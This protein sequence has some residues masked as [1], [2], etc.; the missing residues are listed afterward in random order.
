MSDA[1]IISLIGDH[2]DLRDIRVKELYGYLNKNYLIDAGIKRYILKTYPYSEQTAFECRAESDLLESLAV[3]FT[4]DIPTPVISV[5]GESFLDTEMAGSRVLVRL[6]TF[7]DGEFFSSV[8]PTDSLF[9]SF[10]KFLGELNQSLMKLRIPLLSSREILWDLRKLHAIE[11]FVHLIASARERKLVQHFILNYKEHVLPRQNELKVCLI[12]N[13]A[14]DLNV[15]VKAGQVSGIIDFGDA[16]ESWRINELAIAITYAIMNQDDILGK[17][18]LMVKAFNQVSPLDKVE[19]EVLYYLIG[20]RLCQSVCNSANAKRTDPD[21]EYISVSE[22]AAWSLMARWI[23]INPTDACERFS[24]AAG[25][26]SSHADHLEEEVQIRHKFIPEIVSL[27]YQ[28]PIKMNG[29]AFQYMYGADGTTYLDAYNNIPHVGH[30]HPIVVEAGQR[31]MAR[32][33][34]NTR[35]LY[36]QLADYAGRLLDKFPGPLNKVFFVNS[37][38]E[39]SDLAIRLARNYTGHRGVVVMEH[40]YHG[41]TNTDIEISH[42]KFNNVR[43]PGRSEHIAVAPLPDSYRGIY[44]GDAEA[45]AKY[46]RDLAGQLDAFEEPIAAFISEPVVGCGGQVPLC[47]N[48]LKHVYPEIRRRNALCISDEVQV[49]FGRLGDVFW[50]FEAQGVVPDIVVIGKPM[51]NG[52]PMGAVVTTDKVAAAF[53]QGVEFFSSFGGNP[54]SCEIGQAVLNVLEEE[55]LQNNAREVGDYYKAQ[56]WQLADE[57]PV[58]GDVRGSGL[59]LG[60]ELIHPETGNPNTELAAAVKNGLRNNNILISTDGPFDNVLKSKPPMCFSKENA[61]QVV[62]EIYA[63]LKS[64]IQ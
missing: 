64:Q 45:G 6:L 28:R 25:Y 19:L 58:I 30:N 24:I 10:G 23:C 56:L 55:Q 26:P 27:S 20:A 33:N 47:D 12:H 13:D 2:Y 36:D 14:N 8:D 34:T 50:G 53:N 60:V 38:S 37:G 3:S 41:H 11:P 51:G 32:L 31:Q 61:D 18:S 62:Q 44:A 39:A 57:F 49:G 42:Y 43:G 52:H 4:G 59:F 9:A 5:S 46:A 63:N 17:A 7:V 21:N 54:V 1:A 15:L 35:Y 48:Y 29:A 22:A 40:G 16:V